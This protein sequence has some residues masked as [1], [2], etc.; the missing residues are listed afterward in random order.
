MSGYYWAGL[1]LCLIGTGWAIMR[2]EH[3]VSTVTPVSRLISVVLNLGF[4][5]LFLYGAMHL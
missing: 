5:V 2:P 1:A 4:L 3:S